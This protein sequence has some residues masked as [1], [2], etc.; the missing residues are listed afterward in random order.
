MRKKLSALVLSGLMSCL[1]I[2]PAFAQID[3]MQSTLTEI[4]KVKII[5]DGECTY[6]TVNGS[7]TFT[8]VQEVPVLYSFRGAQKEIIKTSYII[9]PV[10]EEAKVK[11]P[12]RI[13]EIK[14]SRGSGGANTVFGTDTA[15][16]VD[17]N[18]TITYD[19]QTSAGKEYVYLKKVNGGYSADG[20]ESIISGGVTV[21]GNKVTYGQSGVG[22]DGRNKTQNKTYTVGNN[23]RSFSI[24]PPSSWV[25]V[26]AE[27][28]VT[29]V[30]ANY[31][32]TLTR[33]SGSWKC[34][35]INN[36]SF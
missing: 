31:V 25:P 3:N 12:Q 23:N 9:I 15:G 32:I 28:E 7:F 16:C 35:V 8:T 5:Q 24:T 21:S 26:A 17:A 30:G 18:L 19:Y 14:V 4:E 10:T 2:F 20:R 27:S 13:N 36:L 29:T 1:L 6:D 34:E 33:G 22:M 11:L